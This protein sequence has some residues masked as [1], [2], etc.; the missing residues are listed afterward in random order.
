MKPYTYYLYHKP[1]GLKYYGAQWGKN[2]HP[3][4]LWKTYFTSSK[5]VLELIA[6][7]GEDSFIFE[8]RKEFELQE[9][10][11]MWE[12]SV[13][14]KM[15]LHKR[16]DWLNQA[17]VINNHVA[18]PQSTEIRQKI[19][20]TLL[21]RKRSKES[22]EKSRIA[23]TGKS[24]SHKIRKKYS[25][26]QKLR[27]G[28]GP[29]SHTNETKDKIRQRITGMKRSEETKRK[30]SKSAKLREERR[31]QEGWTMPKDSSIQAV[32]T[33][34]KRIANGEINPYSDER[35]KKMGDSKRGKKRKYLPD[36]SFIMVNPKDL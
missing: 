17:T 13:I 25:E 33:R 29:S 21:G 4:N 31:R 9:S 2:S 3:D 27:G 34:Q 30:M 11:M 28:Y 22:I 19:S 1:T 23:L 26:L 35:N 32:K 7:Y 16:D 6:D 36:G 12:Q 10:A 8:I 24:R 15:N 5:K 14:Q 20:K 18:L